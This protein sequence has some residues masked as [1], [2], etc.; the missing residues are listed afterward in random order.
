[1]E[2]SGS[3]Y[4][5]ATGANSINFWTN[6]TSR[7]TLSN[8]GYLG[9]GT[10]TPSYNLHV[11]GDVYATGDLIAYSD[12]NVK[13]DFARIEGALDKICA[14]TGYTYAFRGGDAGAE[15]RHV[16]LIA[17][18]VQAVLPEAVSVDGDGRLG[19]A[20]GN[21]MGLVVEALKGL[22]EEVA[23]LRGGMI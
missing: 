4:I 1:M 17:Q 7:M 16:G 23:A 19:L 9:L 20:Y 5:H 13:K 6:N 3:L 21:L 15:R 18:E 8:N 11:V 22:R 12:S 14:L 10:S 2:A